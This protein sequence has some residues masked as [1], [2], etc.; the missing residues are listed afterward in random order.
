MTKPAAKP[1]LPALRKSKAQSKVIKRGPA[2]RLGLVITPSSVALVERTSQSIKYHHVP[3][4]EQFMT[5]TGFTDAN[6]LTAAVKNLRTQLNSKIRHV[7]VHF[8]SMYVQMNMLDVPNVNAGN[9]DEVEL[10]GRIRLKTTLNVDETTSNVTL[11]PADG[12]AALAVFTA[13]KKLLGIITEAV[14]AAGLTVSALVPTPITALNGINTPDGVTA[15]LYFEPDGSSIIVLQDQKV[16]YVEHMAPVTRAIIRTAADS[17]QVTAFAKLETTSDWNPELIGLAIDKQITETNDHLSS[18]KLPNIQHILAAGHLTQQTPLQAYLTQ[19]IGA[20]IAEGRISEYGDMPLLSGAVA[21]PANDARNIR[22]LN[23]LTPDL[24]PTSSRS[25]PNIGLIIPLA[26]TA[27]WAGYAG[28][29]ALKSVSMQQEATSK[30]SNLK[31]LQRFASEQQ[32]LQAEN[33]SIQTTL[34]LRQQIEA[35]NTPWPDIIARFANDMPT[36][37]RGFLATISSITA[38]EAKPDATKFGELPV[39][40]AYDITANAA[41]RS[42]ILEFIRTFSSTPYAID[43]QRIEQKPGVGWQVSATVGTIK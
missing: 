13:D 6:L 26:L 5:T 11:Y 24:K 12:Q 9:P 21:T 3:I 15:L 25:T 30:E 8:P 29:V 17:S 27:A 1:R 18:L 20:Q 2:Q 31:E 41:S 22:S 28:T 14:T 37:E 10:G 42:N 19:E 39:S 4:T 38:R 7:D 16:V 36:N 32:R 35:G 33:T 23:L 40:Y 43:V 34:S